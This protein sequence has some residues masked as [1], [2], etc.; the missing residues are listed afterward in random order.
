MTTQEDFYI[1][2]FNTLSEAHEDLGYVIMFINS[3]KLDDAK[4]ITQDVMKT[5]DR[6]K[7]N[8]KGV[9]NGNKNM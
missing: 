3:N 1:W 8:L 2:M 7:R 9:M 4:D 5:I 6:L